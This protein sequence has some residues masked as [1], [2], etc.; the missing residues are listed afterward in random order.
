M[1]I[2]GQPDKVVRL[3][4]FGTLGLPESTVAAFA[5]TVPVPAAWKGRQVELVFDAEQWFWGILPQGRLLVNGQEAAVKQP[6]VPMPQPSFSCDVTAAAASGTV[7]IRLEI[8]GVSKSM[9]RNEKN[10]MSAPHG[11]TGL[12]YLQGT[13]PAVKTEPLTGPWSI[14]SAFNRLQPV[15]PGEKVKGLY[16]ETR[17]TLP[18]VWPAKQLFLESPLPLGFV[19]LNGYVLQAPSSMK[20][21][22]VSGLVYRDGRENV[23]RWT[24][25]SRGVAAWNRP[26]DGVVPELSKVWVE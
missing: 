26:Y 6:L 12:F 4:A 16:L 24:P 2:D 7:A 22:D 20:R 9:M 15:K 10:G 23:L 14:A 5:K 13:A 25:A 3:G 8:D 21:L 19:V 11:V 17:F 1:K 18:Q